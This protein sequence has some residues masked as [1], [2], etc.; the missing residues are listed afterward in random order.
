MYVC[1]AQYRFTIGIDDPAWPRPF[2]YPD[3]ILS[4]M[5]LWFKPPHESIPPNSIDIDGGY[6]ESLYTIIGA[7]LI[8]SAV[9]GWCVGMAI[10]NRMAR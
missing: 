1:F 9:S 5:F 8:L 10:P 7:A 6:N 2:P 3:Q 4:Q